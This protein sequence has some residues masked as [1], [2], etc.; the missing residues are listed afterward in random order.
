MN[1]ERKIMGV[2][3]ELLQ[4]IEAGFDIVDGKSIKNPSGN[5][6]IDILIKDEKKQAR[7][8]KKY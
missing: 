4:I 6:I 5:E 8:V 1:K 2:G 3:E 7:K